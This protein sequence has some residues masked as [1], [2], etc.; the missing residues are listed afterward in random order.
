MTRSTW[1]RAT[2]RHHSSGLARRQ[3]SPDGGEAGHST[4]MGS[5]L[6][7]V[8]LRGNPRDTQTGRGPS[9]D[10]HQT[11]QVIWTS[12][13]EG[14]WGRRRVLT[15]SARLRTGP[16]RRGRR[17]YK[18]PL[19]LGPH[20]PAAGLLGYAFRARPRD[21][22]GSTRAPLARPRAR[23]GAGPCRSG[24][25]GTIRSRQERRNEI[26]HILTIE[27]EHSTGPTATAIERERGDA[28]D[29]VAATDVVWPTGV[30]KT[31]A[32]GRGVVRQQ[33]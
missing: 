3:V 18:L 4:D 15:G 9:Q 13:K 14:H 5:P 24:L 20:S 7:R 1:P 21:A 28:A 25:T 23:L 30:A 17:P 29:R 10:L 32:A 8:G 2:R 11:N 26:E 22:N 27:T 12:Q 6:T 16:R 19:T 33:Q 31:G